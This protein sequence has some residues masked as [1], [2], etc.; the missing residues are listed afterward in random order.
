MTLRSLGIASDILVGGTSQVIESHTDRM[1]L[2]T[3]EQPSYW[4]GNCVT[5]R[6]YSGDK[7][8]DISQFRADFPQ[9]PHICIQWDVPDLD[10]DLS[11]WG[12][13][14]FQIDDTD[15]LVLDR[16]IRFPMP[17]GIAVRRV[18]RAADWAQVADL[19]HRT[20][21]EEDGHPEAAHLDYVERRFDAH[22]A[23]SG[24]G[25]AKWFGAFDGDLLVADM[26]LYSDGKI[27]RFQSVE[28]RPSHR[29][30][31]ICA[32]LVGEVAARAVAVHVVM[33][34]DRNGAPG[35]IYRRCGFRPSERLMA[36]VKRGY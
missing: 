20:G 12:A 6:G 26:G 19:Q 15:V 4:F 21:V 27:A 1:V 14:G 23:A 10:A 35:R 11:E 7:D 25:R 9:A 2:R 33:I 3:P 16:L 5:F 18:E 22:R 30:R 8:A 34:A 24:A 28:T 31:G 36:V 13:D 29:G 32:A 17:E